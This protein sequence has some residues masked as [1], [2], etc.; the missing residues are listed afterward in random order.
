[1][2]VARRSY[3]F[4]LAII[5]ILIAIVWQI[6]SHKHKTVYF[7]A[8]SQVVQKQSEVQHVQPFHDN[9]NHIDVQDFSDPAKSKYSDSYALPI[10]K[11][12]QF[13]PAMKE[14]KLQLQYPDGHKKIQGDYKNGKPIGKWH[15]WY[16]NGQ[17]AIEMNWQKGMP[18]GRTLSW[19]ENGQKRGELY[20]VNGKAEGRWQRW[21][22]NGQIKQDMSV[23]Q[24]VV[25]T[26]TTWDDKGHLL[27]DVAIHKN[28]VS[29]V[30]LSWYD[31][32]AKKSESIFEKNELVRKTEWDEDGLVVDLDGN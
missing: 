19:Y 24:G 10:D 20:F 7:D 6:K 5:L 31:S 21:Y 26:M 8:N 16:P 22:P 12:Q 11:L 28:K 15:T 3:W 30:V 18:N 4:V 2:Y 27:A 14:G 23:H 17:K 29:G 25:Q 1:M 32:G 13:I 9:G